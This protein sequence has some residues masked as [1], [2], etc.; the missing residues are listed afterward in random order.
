MVVERDAP[1]AAKVDARA[2]CMAPGLHQACAL[3][4]LPRL[5]E[6]ACVCSMSGLMHAGTE[7]HRYIQKEDRRVEKFEIV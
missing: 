5:M 6:E 1:E 7:I 3:L 4:P 2:A